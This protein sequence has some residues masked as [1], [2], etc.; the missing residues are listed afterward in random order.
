MQ[1]LELDGPPSRFNNQARKFADDDRDAFAASVIAFGI[2]PAQNVQIEILT[3]SRGGVKGARTT[4]IEYKLSSTD[5]AALDEAVANINDK[6][7]EG[8]EFKAREGVKRTWPFKSNTEVAFA[9]VDGEQVDEQ[10]LDLIA[11]SGED[12]ASYTWYAVSAAAVV[13]IACAVAACVVYRK[14]SAKEAVAQ[15]ELSQMDNVEVDV[16]AVPEAATTLVAENV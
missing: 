13:M 10:A 12:D 15:V 8:A 5:P 4:I 11:E 9:L 3:R 1:D 2:D 6:V 16:E 7:S 14:R